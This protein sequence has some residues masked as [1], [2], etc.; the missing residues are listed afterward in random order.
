MIESKNAGS[1]PEARA[2]AISTTATAAA[3]RITS[4]YSA[5]V[6]PAS[7]ASRRPMRMWRARTYQ[8][9]S[10]PV[11]LL[12]GDVSGDRTDGG[13]E[14]GDHREQEERGEDEEHQREQHLDRG[15]S[16]PLGGGG[17]P[18][19]PNVGGEPGDLIGQGRADRLGPRQRADQS[20][21]V[22]KLQAIPRGPQLVGHR[23]PRS[24]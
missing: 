9:N 2:H 7:S 8:D 12:S 6:C 1:L 13:E 23:P 4:A 24:V 22:G 19:L 18:H 15:R 17:P 10:I 11:H 14:D 16:G 3:A 5:V 21:E 20:A